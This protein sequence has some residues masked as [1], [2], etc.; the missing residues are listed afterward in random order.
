MPE[1]S[2][3]LVELIGMCDKLFRL[4][5]GLVALTYLD[6]LRGCMMVIDRWAMNG[7]V[8]KMT[9]RTDRVNKEGAA[10]WMREQQFGLECRV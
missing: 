1:F 7:S 4:P 9:Q 3:S 5:T 2:P 8:S 6:F 10:V